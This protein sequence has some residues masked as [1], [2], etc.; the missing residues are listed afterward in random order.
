MT[1]KEIAKNIVAGCVSPA[2]HALPELETVIAAAIDGETKRLREAL[3]SQRAV[4][5]QLAKPSD[6]SAPVAVSLRDI[7]CVALEQIDGALGVVS[8]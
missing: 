8:P 3:L 5:E 1:S 6:R 2:G 4:W 7:A